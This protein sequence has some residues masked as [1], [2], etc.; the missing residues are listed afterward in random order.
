MKASRLPIASRT[1]SRKTIREMPTDYE[2]ISVTEL[3]H[4]CQNDLMADWCAT[5]RK[6][7]S[8]HE[9]H[10]SSLTFLFEKGKEHE[11]YIISTI[12]QKTGLALERHSSHPTSRLYTERD[13]VIDSYKVIQSMK[14]GDPIIYSAYLADPHRRL[15]GIPDLLVRND[16][17][18]IL[19][20]E[21]E[22][23]DIPTGVSYFGNYYYIP[24][25]IKFSTVHLA[26]DGL[27]VTNVDRTSFYK[28]QL[29]AYGSLLQT[30][31]GWTPPCAFLIG[32]RTVGKENIFH[33]LIRPG[34][35]DY[36]GYD[37]NFISQFYEGIEWLRRVKKYGP[38]W[39]TVEDVM[40]HAPPNMKCED[41]LY[42]N[43]KKYISSTA[44]DIT[45]I[46]RCGVKQRQ[47]A[48]EQGI[49][50]WCDP[51]LNADIMNI[52]NSYKKQVDAILKVNRGELDEY[53]FEFKNANEIQ[54]SENMFVDFE[55]IRDTFDVYRPLENPEFIFLIGVYYKNT[56]HSF[57]IKSLTTENEKDLITT[58]HKFWVDCGKPVCWF[59]YAEKELWRRALARTG[60]Q[61]DV[62]WNDLYKIV[63]SGPFVV[64]GC[65]NF[66]LKS[67]IKAMSEMSLIPVTIPPES[68]DNGM[69]A[70][71]MAWKY[72]KD[73]NQDKMIKEQNMK[74][75]IAYN[76]FDCTSLYHILTFMQKH[77]QKLSL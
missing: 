32:K 63:E 15:R 24:V 70:M 43:D 6:D 73:E 16:R 4:F 14:Q 76:E 7:D 13:G 67:Y 66:K 61:I 30:I 20:P 29:Y 75:I 23:P 56:Y 45:E 37:I 11:D 1:R 48:R 57:Q 69:D 22:I 59:W 2:W 28:T 27:H 18:H 21:Y 68:C 64:R 19:F 52:P 33:S 26:S 12:R 8:L 74:N 71:I 44:G 62:K 31:Q 47:L 65:K 10:T 55:T 36:T 49:T 39:S 54:H 9:T 41:S 77:V 34:Y 40:K 58:F 5:F 72:Y 42:Q 35:I 3:D 60:I 50:T 17:I 51:R 46:W 53:S 25:E 38:A